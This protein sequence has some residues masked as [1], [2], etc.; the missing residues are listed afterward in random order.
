MKFKR[1]LQ[2]RI[3][4]SFIPAV[5]LVI[6][7]GFFL[8][9]AE[10]PESRA[11]A[12][13]VR[14][15]V[16]A[17]V[18]LS[19][20][21]MSYLQARA[22]AKRIEAVAKSAAAIARGQFD[23]RTEVTSD[24][25]VG[26]LGMAFNQMAAQLTDLI[27]NQELRIGER[28]RTIEAS[29][30]VSRQLST[31]LN[32]DEL[33]TAVVE[34]L[35]ATFNY[36]HAQ[37]YLLDE[38][39]EN[40]VMAGGTGDVGRTLLV[41]NHHVP[42]GKGL[43]GGAAAAQ[44][45]ILVPDV[46]QE[47]R[48]LSNPLLPDTK[49]EAAVPI[50]RG[51]QFVGVLDVQNDEVGSLSQHDVDLLST[52]ASQVA[53]ALQNATLFKQQQQ[54]ASLLEKEKERI[55]TIL[56]TIS[57]SVAIS[58]VAEGKILYANK[59]LA[60]AI[61]FDQD[62]IIGQDTPDFYANPA[63]REQFLAR[64]QAQEGVHNYEIQ[65]NRGE[66]ELAWAM[67]SAQLI[68]YE[69]QQAIL[70]TI[71]NI[72]DRKLAEARAV[73]LANELATVA[74]VSTV[75]STRLEPSALLQAV[76]D[77]TKEGFGLYHAH[78]LLFN[79]PKN[80]LVLMAGAGEVGQKMVEEGRQI[81]LAAGGSLIAAAARRKK[82]VIR[83]YSTEG[84][85]F[86]PHPLLAETR[87]EMAVPIM[88]ED[89][90]LGVLDVRSEQT[91]YFSEADAQTYTTL[92]AQVAVALQNARSFARSE[93]AVTELQELSRRLTR[94]GWHDYLAQRVEE[95]AI[96]YDLQRPATEP[97]EEETETA[98]PTQ[99]DHLLAQTLQIQGEPIGQLKVAS[100]KEHDEE[101]AEIVAA[102]AE[103]LSVHLENLRL[104]EQS[105]IARASAE[106]R[107]QELAVINNIVTQISA[108]LDLQH[109][110]QIIVDELATAVNVDQ[111]RV[112]LLQP[113]GQEM[114][115]IA[116]HYD[117]AKSSSALGAT[118]P[119]AGNALTQQVL[120]TRALTV[121]EDAQNSSLT[122]PVHE[123][124]RQQGIETVIIIPLVVNDEVIGTIGLDILDKR[125]VDADSLQLAETIVYQAATAVQNARLF[126][127]T[128]AA[129]AETELLY[130]CSTQLNEAANLDAVL[131]AAVSSALS[132]GAKSASLLVLDQGGQ[133][134]A[135]LGTIVAA[136]AETPH[137]VNTQYR[138]P[139]EFPLSQ[140]WTFNLKDVLFVS[141][142][143]SDSRLQDAQKRFCH[144]AGVR[145][146]ILMFL[147][148][149][150]LRLGQITI[151]W[152][153][154]QTFTS[155]DERL[156]GSIAQQAASV[157]YNRMLFNQT[158]EA[159][160]ETAA[161]YQ[162]TTDLNTASTYDEVLTTLRQY[163]ILG[164][165][166][167]DVSLN[168]FAHPWNKE[169]ENSPGEIEIVARSS[170]MFESFPTR[171]RIDDFPDAIQVLKPDELFVC[172]DVANDERLD[173]KSRSLFL[174]RFQAK[175]FLLVPLVVGGQWLGFVSGLFAHPMQFPEAELRRVNV[176]ARQ[177][178][179][180]IQTIRLLEQTNLLLAS[181]QRQRQVA[182]NLLEA[183]TH[184]SETLSED[185]LRQIILEQI[186]K[187][188]LPDHINFY[189]WQTADN[190]L[191]LERRFLA[192]EDHQEDDF[193]LGQVITQVERPELLAV[194]NENSPL[195]QYHEGE[196]GLL[197]E[198]YA[199]PWFVGS[200]IAGLI[201]IYHTARHLTI[202]E[203]DQLRCE[204]VVRQAAIAI[205]NA[206]LYEQTQAALA[207]TEVLYD[208]LAHIVRSSSEDDVLQALIDS[209]VLK[210]FDRAN[211]FLFDHPLRFDEPPGDVTV[212]AEWQNEGVPSAVPIG[213]R[214]PVAH[215]PFISLLNPEGPMVVNDVFE[216]DRID[217][218]TK[219]IL[220][221]FGTRSFVVFP[222]FV[223]N[224]WLG[225]VAGLSITPTYLNEDQLR[226]ANS[227]VSQATVVMQTT[228][229][230][231]QEQA[232]AHREHLLREIAAK[233]RG[234]TDV[235]TIMRTAVT[236][237]GRTLGRRS[238]I[239]LESSQPA[240]GQ[241]T[242]GEAQN[243]A[244]S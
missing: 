166:S 95:V 125:S 68:E 173:E 82:A 221:Q 22:I 153:K 126:E 108:S 58:S 202:R 2:R 45:P 93:Q 206:R 41:Q 48:W 234:S 103:R 31:I 135:E 107:G 81:S 213:T 131:K 192:A 76:V 35:K 10:R 80:A 178:A 12:P 110:L 16:F 89:E 235:D 201:E 116:E 46:S 8:L 160:S 86:M 70:T 243:G 44:Q 145:A 179:V 72:N 137:P 159:L 84:E 124:F 154:P 171:Y 165:N 152:G 238:F 142:V 94:E 187:I 115:I 53:V 85:G 65:L 133:S 149:G 29:A 18:V 226:Q 130:T 64:L 106:K 182:N 209:T 36:Y 195:L 203:E 147:T 198:H 111:V 174:N 4:L 96:R 109:S 156:Y 127:Q 54:A 59:S 128:Q 66:D 113:D 90:V 230:F 63:D 79:E 11:I 99:D 13:G 148:V 237:I 233:V 151:Y 9:G 123:L 163:T 42:F 150:N 52:I 60:Q 196:D 236:E 102:V 217:A 197:R 78:I 19:T 140:L 119:V 21:F 244:T 134:N 184:L 49:A 38:A 32:P 190:S 28:T 157:V 3:L 50:M 27:E 193:T 191:K 155:A 30:E 87:A 20:V 176:L 73:K 204:G 14:F 136:T 75:A 161:L 200:Q 205:Q 168:Y 118:I 240:N 224:Q 1:T 122:E 37:I 100:P 91:G 158:E 139:D 188:L 170:V 144:D 132:I 143:D 242:S 210:Q 181:E 55:Q 120:A 33:T 223:G 92:A 71:A 15:A 172:E 229:L 129:L 56:E 239:K 180:S 101:A 23:E 212:A 105:D 67:V 121:V 51:E 222:L 199:L 232:R 104:A 186:N 185:Q 25:E 169:K 214:F 177:A 57:I 220:E 26:Q 138:L 17:S 62:E 117:A 5:I 39:G 83:N 189:D 227:L 216:D 114:L 167:I 40:L 241:T 231:R 24:D 97:K 77:R 34:Q 225:V 98:A 146:L 211:L 215:V 183:A 228:N 208:G 207:E 69:G 194:L 88:L 47:P 112:A 218:T 6:M 43:V 219:A 74:E 7:A 164:H 162:A 175:G 61:G 141:D